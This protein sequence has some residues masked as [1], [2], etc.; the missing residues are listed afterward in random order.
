MVTPRDP[1]ELSSGSER[2]VWLVGL[3]AIIALLGLF[4]LA[5][6]SFAHA[7]TWDI[8]AMNKQ[9]DQTNVLV[10]AGGQDFCSGTV[11]SKKY[12]LILTANHCVADQVKREEK[13]FIDPVTGEVTKKTIEKKLDMEVSQRI[14][15]NYEIVG[16][17]RLLAKIKGYDSQNDVALLQVVDE[18][19][20]AEAEAK[21]APDNPALR[22]GDSIFVIGNPGIEFDNS[23]TAGIVSN[24]ER[25]LDFGDGNKLKV[26]Q[27]DAAAIGGNSGGSVVNM[28]GELIGT[29]DAGLRQ[30]TITFA[31]PI[32]QTKALLR[33]S[34]FRDVLGEAKKVGDATGTGKIDS[35]GDVP[36]KPKGGPFKAGP[37]F[38]LMHLD[39]KP[40]WG[41]LLEG[42]IEAMR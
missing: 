27:I 16:T 32:S 23:I 5:G 39:A 36:A 15:K 25:V 42:M 30:S 20:A 24:T 7:E 6:V 29:L 35:A 9:I 28:K 14:T 40:T 33:S 13:E 18:A 8:D 3:G 37:K 38:T 31:V 26:I 22:R 2:F 4:I 1:L 41:R 21:L 34:G 11:I 19:W 12:R 10:G 17:H